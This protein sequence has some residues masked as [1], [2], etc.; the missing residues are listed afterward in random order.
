MSNSR[1]FPI[2]FVVLFMGA[3]LGG[4]TATVPV[5]PE[6]YD[7]VAE[8]FQPAPGMGNI[9]V[10]RDDGFAGS[11]IAFRIELDGRSIGSIAPGTYHLFELEPG[12]HIVAASTQENADHET[13]N[14]M[15][16]ENYFI[17]IEP[18]WGMIAAR[19]SLEMVE[20]ERG[21]KLV[22]DGSR[23]ESLDFD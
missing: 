14:V 12:D 2:V 17:E 23:A 11:A 16:G 7:Q 1:I 15:E 10:V 8:Q 4:C 5:M 22:I 19:V 9:Y 6:Q 21:Q 13:V 3:M 20:F 18:K